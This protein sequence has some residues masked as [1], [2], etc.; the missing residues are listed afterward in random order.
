ME[1]R[2]DT[3]DPSGASHWLCREMIRFWNPLLTL[4]RNPDSDGK[5]YVNRLNKKWTS[6]M[7]K[8]VKR[9]GWTVE[10]NSWMP[11][12]DPDPFGH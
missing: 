7:K 10:G 9:E 4:E 3:N 5:L 12:V 6:R 1:S 8:V 11:G 2:L